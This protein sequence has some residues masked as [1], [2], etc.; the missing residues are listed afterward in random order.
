M[1]A[2]QG[3]L[4]ILISMFIILCTINIMTERGGVCVCVCVSP[5]HKHTYI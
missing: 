3:K 5:Y 2:G 1:F 4:L